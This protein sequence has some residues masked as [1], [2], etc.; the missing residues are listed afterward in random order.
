M[1]YL[2]RFFLV[3]AADIVVGWFIDLFAILEKLMKKIKKD[4]VGENDDDDDDK[5]FS[6]KD[7]EEEDHDDESKEED[8]HEKKHDTEHSD[9]LLTEE[10][11]EPLPYTAKLKGSAYD[12]KFDMKSK[13]VTYADN[14]MNDFGGMIN[15]MELVDYDWGQGQDKKFPNKDFRDDGEVYEMKSQRNSN[16]SSRNTLDKNS[17][18]GEI[19]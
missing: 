19:A 1:L 8:E 16:S 5:F 15:Q 12:R 7:E 6:E 3:T 11:F 10:N 4:F 9:I 2:E 17:T 18:G 13:V 14:G